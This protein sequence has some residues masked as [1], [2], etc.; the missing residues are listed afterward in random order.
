MLGLH[1]LLIK[2]VKRLPRYA[3]LLKAL[4]EHTFPDHP[5]HHLIRQ[6][7][8][9]IQ[10]VL[11]Q[12]NESIRL[13]SEYEKVLEV[14]QRFRKNR[15]KM[16]VLFQT[17]RFLISQGKLNK[18]TSHGVLT[19][20]RFFL[21]NDLLL[22]GEKLRSSPHY[23]KF[24]GAIPLGMCWLR[25]LEDTG[26][27]QNLFKVVA[28]QKTST[29]FT[30]TPEM[31]KQWM[32]MINN[33]INA[34]IERDPSLVH[35][36]GPVRV[37]LPSTL[38]TTWDSRLNVLKANAGDVPLDLA[39]GEYEEEQPESLE[40]S[41]TPSPPPPSPPPTLREQFDACKQSVRSCFTEPWSAFQYLWLS[42]AL[43]QWSDRLWSFAIPLVL[44]SLFPSS[45]FPSTFY[46]FCSSLASFLLGPLIG[47]W[48]DG[49][50]RLR[51]VRLS[52]IVQNS[53]VV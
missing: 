53:F 21:F 1:D 36:R 49:N 5:D 45:M 47:R 20:V 6:A 27:V 30:D 8:E 42:H 33:Q 13:A 31:K 18:I 4:L 19:K 15:K 41:R 50:D 25:D 9:A 35:K 16:P 46:P 52:L 11:N 28:P 44:S 3:L 12:T 37:N 2:P 10:S 48:I 40:G 22:Y 26:T 51:V 38:F 29:L 17:G 39:L 24:K 7:M 14:I 23:L 34:L 43:G 32:A